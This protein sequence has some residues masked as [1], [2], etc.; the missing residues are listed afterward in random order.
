MPDNRDLDVYLR[1]H[2]QRDLRA[3]RVQSSA[4][5]RRRPLVQYV[6]SQKGEGFVVHRNTCGVKGGGEFLEKP[7]VFAEATSLNI[8]RAAIP[9]GYRR[10]PRRKDDR[11]DVVEVWV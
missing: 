6:V 2:G 11:V 5:A 10:L 4:E 7:E 9:A 1:T 8:A 3:E